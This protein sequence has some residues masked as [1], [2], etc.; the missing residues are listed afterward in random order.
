M[1][2]CPE[3]DQYVGPVSFAPAHLP[4]K[5]EFLTAPYRLLTCC[6]PKNSDILEAYAAADLS[7]IR[8]F[9]DIRSRVPKRPKIPPQ[10]YFTFT[11]VYRAKGHIYPDQNALRNK[12]PISFGKNFRHRAYSR[13]PVR[14]GG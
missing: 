12:R 6:L 2:L 14:I 10:Y 9:R 13:Q 5:H 7:L 1:T 3:A 11:M 4:N 8:A